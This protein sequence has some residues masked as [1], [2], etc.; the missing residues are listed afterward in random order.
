MKWTGLVVWTNIVLLTSCV[1]AQESAPA[2]RTVSGTGSVI[3]KQM[4]TTMRMSI[5]FKETGKDLTDALKNLKDRREAAKAQLVKLG[6]KSDSMREG[7]PANVADDPQ[8]AQ[9]MMMMANAR[10]GGKKKKAA[11]PAK[12]TISARLS[13]EWPLPSGSMEEVMLFAQTVKDKVQAADLAGQKEQKKTT[14]EEQEEMEEMEMFQRQY[15]GRSEAKPG[16]PSYVYLAKIS[17]DDQQKAR[18]AAF[19][20]ARLQAVQLADAAGT[21]LGKLRTL[22]SNSENAS[23][24]QMMAYN[25]YR[26]GEDEEESGDD[27]DADD[28]QLGKS[29]VCAKVPFAFVIHA[30]FDINE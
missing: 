26:N 8:A 19:K 5:Q 3:V 4:P 14:A 20:K 7:A 15:G 24:Y 18:A 21:K 30:A 27:D 29:P 1:V 28:E 25:R 16:E 17:A 13:C 22:Q 11:A 9:A 23:A 12:V 2:P 10:P 6:A